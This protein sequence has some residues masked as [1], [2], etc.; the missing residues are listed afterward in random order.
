MEN[1]KGQLIREA[2]PRS[3]YPVEKDYWALLRKPLGEN[4]DGEDAKID[5]YS[6]QRYIYLKC[7]SK[8]A[9]AVFFDYLVGDEPTNMTVICDETNRDEFRYILGVTLLHIRNKISM[10]ELREKWGDHDFFFEVVDSS[11]ERSKFDNFQDLI[12]KIEAFISK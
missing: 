2:T 1:K 7:N 4:Q 10:N 5:S 12:D 6:G 8:D 3:G 9:V 11:E